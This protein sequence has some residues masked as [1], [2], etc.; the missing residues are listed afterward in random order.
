MLGHSVAQPARKRATHGSSVIEFQCI[1][2]IFFNEDFET[3][4]GKKIESYLQDEKH[5]IL[6]QYE[7]HKVLCITVFLVPTY[8]QFAELGL[9]PVFASQNESAEFQKAA[10]VRVCFIVDTFLTKAAKARKNFRVAVLGKH[11][12]LLKNFRLNYLVAPRAGDS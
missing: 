6:I 9:G 11:K 12:R 7:H 3:E 1:L 4:E 8:S 10:T 2:I 5:H